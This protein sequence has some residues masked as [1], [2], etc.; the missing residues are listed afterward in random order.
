VA[1][2]GTAGQ[3]GGFFNQSI[4]ISG[5]LRLAR[6]V[7]YFDYLN[8]RLRLR[9]AEV[10]LAR[11]VRSD[12]YAA[13]IAAENVRVTRLVVGFTEE[14]YR[15]QVAMV[16]GGT[17][18][19]FEAAALRAVV[20][21]VRANLIQARNRYASAWRQLA[22]TANAPDL[23]LAVLAGRPDDTAPAL[24]YEALRDRLLAVHT[25][26]AAAQNQVAQAERSLTLERRRPIPDLENNF[27]FQNDTQANSFQLGVQVGVQVPV[28]NRNQG[29]I[30][31]AAAQ[32]ARSGREVERVRNGLL[33]E[34]ADAFGRYESARQ[35]LE[36]YQNLILPDLVRAF[37]GVN[38]RYQVEPDK[39][40]YNDIVTAQQNLAAQLNNY[41]QVLQQQ[42]QAVADLAGIVQVDDPAELIIPPVPAVPGP[43]PVVP[44]PGR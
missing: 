14:V 40:N 37:R 18:A 4:P 25:D 32:L 21:Q 10:D 20:G 29:G 43:G 33:R 11:Q 22:A 41:L 23:P 16:R 38:E 15:R 35:Q 13:L 3:Q 39:V 28:F 19:A 8:A 17:A 7:A 30:M 12:Y 44:G 9:R 6:S 31:S 36:L 24:R 2:L 5:R 26:L 1:N 42:W 34:L 27:Y